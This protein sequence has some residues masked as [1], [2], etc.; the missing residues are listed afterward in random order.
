MTLLSNRSNAL[1]EWLLARRN[2]LPL[3]FFLLTLSALLIARPFWIV[4]DSL[5]L[6]IPCL[7]VVLGG[8]LVRMLTLGYSPPGSRLQTRGF[9]ALC[10]HPLE[11]GS[12]LIGLGIL[13]YAGVLGWML[14][15]GVLWGWT[16]EKVLLAEEKRLRRK[17]GPAY[18]EYAASTN[19]LLPVWQNWQPT[20]TPFSWRRALRIGKRDLLG[21]M[22]AM[23]LISVLKVRVVSFGWSIDPFWLIT[24]AVTVALW[25]LTWVL[26]KVMR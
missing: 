7:V 20:D 14:T 4:P 22:M 17:F 19:A 15:G 6:N 12:L 25:L 24:M 16:I 11:W 21:V 13:A 5:W 23:S 2:R 26:Q 3:W 1:G 10:R 9:Y 8:I 18:A